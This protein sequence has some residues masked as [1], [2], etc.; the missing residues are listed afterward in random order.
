MG[1]IEANWSG[2]ARRVSG[3]DQNLDDLRQAVGGNP[4]DIERRDL[5]DGSHV[6]EIRVPHSDGFSR[7]R[8]AAVVTGD[9]ATLERTS[10]AGS[11]YDTI[12]IPAAR[13][14]ANEASS[15]SDGEIRGFTH[16]ELQFAQPDP[17]SPS[18]RLVE[19][20]S[21]DRASEL[22]GHYKR[23]GINC[24]K[25]RYKDSRIYGV[26][27]AADDLINI[28]TR[29]PPVF[30]ATRNENL[31]ARQNW[32]DM[33]ISR[34]GIRGEKVEF[35]VKRADVSDKDNEYRQ[36]LLGELQSLGLLAKAVLSPTLRGIYIEVSG[37]DSMLKL[38]AVIAEGQK[39]LTAAGNGSADKTAGAVRGGWGWLGRF[40]PAAFRK[41]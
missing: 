34:N 30:T 24:Q 7:R 37:Y 8:L 21:R 20:A 41:H 39:T 33:K 18:L 3:S 28:I 31:I 6:Y 11:T 1:D 22:V 25:F 32:Q 2:A 29:R 17:E 13:L 4:F 27:L 9:P 19:V 14:R 15:N 10:E 40:S 36:E 35:D 26:S 23:A 5:P 16:K 38:P 12:V